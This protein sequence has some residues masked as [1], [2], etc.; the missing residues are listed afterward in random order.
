LGNWG[1]LEGGIL[2][3][4]II[5][6]PSNSSEYWRERLPVLPSCPREINWDFNNLFYKRYIF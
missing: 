1:R 5:G 3:K 4:K 2:N 6:W